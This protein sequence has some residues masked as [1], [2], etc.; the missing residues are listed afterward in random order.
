MPH[1]IVNPLKTRQHY[2]F[3]KPKHSTLPLLSAENLKKP[4]I[5]Q[6][7]PYNFDPA[8][9]ALTS[10]S[11]L[12]PFPHI[13]LTRSLFACQSLHLKAL[14]CPLHT[15]NPGPWQSHRNV[16]CHQ[17]LLI[18]LYVLSLLYV[19]ALL[20]LARPYT[21]NAILLSMSPKQQPKAITVKLAPKTPSRYL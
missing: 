17:V 19:T 12:L 10:T 14:L 20:S 15:L 2:S 4:K 1:P 7:Q 9:S 5:L 21:P 3:R 18:G 6:P 13:L 8:S 16:L 11:L